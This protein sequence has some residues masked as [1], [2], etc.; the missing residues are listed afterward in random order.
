MTIFEFED[1]RK[2]IRFWVSSKDER[3]GALTRMAEAMAV[4]TTMLSQVLAGDKNLSPEMADRLVGHLGLTE[5]ES[6]FFFLLLDFQRAGTHSLKQ[7]F[8]ARMK[9]LSVQAKDLEHRVKKDQ[10]LEDFAKAI[11]YSSWIYTGVRNLSA[12]T[13]FQ[14]ID[15]ISTQL[16]VS[17]E[18]L[19]RVIHFLL[20]NDLIKKEGERIQP[21]S[22]ITHLPAK[23]PLVTKH[24]QNWRLRGFQKMDE[25]REDDFFFTGPMSMSRELAEQVRK[26]LPTFL[27]KLGERLGPSSSEVVRCLNI[28][29]FEY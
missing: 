22:K 28:D 8:K 3:R 15:Q 9:V 24:H 25:F 11:Y 13:D 23:S 12:I 4:S 5:K 14:N 6:E 21:K 10:E 18:T 20:E 17:R 1:Y 27:E 16:Q 29:W 19:M 7:R 26:E 2:F